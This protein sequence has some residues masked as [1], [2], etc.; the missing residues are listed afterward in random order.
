MTAY[1]YD[2]FHPKLLL[3]DAAFSGG[4]KPGERFPNFDL[5]ATDGRR[6]TLKDLVAEKPLLLTFASVT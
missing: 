4:P 5:P 3:E 1:R 6:Y 2:H